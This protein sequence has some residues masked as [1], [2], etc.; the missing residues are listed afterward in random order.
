MLIGL[1]GA[2]G[3]VARYGLGGLVQRFGSGGF[4]WGTLFVNLV[5]CLL[6]GV[7]VSVAEHRFQVEE[8]T[9][10]MVLVGFMGAFTT[11]STLAFHTGDYIR[12][13]QWFMA[14]ANLS[15]HNIVGV[16]C[17]LAGLYLGRVL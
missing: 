3:T 10:N 9:R 14:L 17:I 8:H 16:A 7:F 6:F 11:F 12:D 2:V 4:P 15:A 1:A 13:N 5:G